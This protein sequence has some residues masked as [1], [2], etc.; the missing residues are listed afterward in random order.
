MNAPLS[1]P[2]F[3][4]KMVQAKMRTTDGIFIDPRSDPGEHTRGARGVCIT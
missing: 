1:D 4:A 3:R 2:A